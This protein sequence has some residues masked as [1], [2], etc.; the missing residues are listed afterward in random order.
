MSGNGVE[1]REWEGCVKKVYIET[2][3]VSYYASDRSENIR[4]AGHQ[5]STVALWK[6]LHEFD[7]YVS[8]V[9]VGEVSKGSADQ[10]ALRFGAIAS[11]EMLE[12]ESKAGEL[13]ELLLSEKAIPEKCPEDAMHI[14]V[15]AVNGMD[16]IVTWNFKHIN[17]PF[18]KKK[19]DQVV[20]MSGYHCPVL[21]SPDELLGENDD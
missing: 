17:N 6:R 2:S 19:I 5:L 16:F 10:V 20:E 12:V 9:V 8:D 14:A 4:I 13:T 15:A 3:V 21:C 7:V 18:M 1:F 11:F